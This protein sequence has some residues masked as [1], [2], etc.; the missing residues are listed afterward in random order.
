M[1]RG[2]AGALM[3]GSLLTWD[4]MFHVGFYRFI[5]TTHNSAAASGIID[6]P[7]VVQDISTLF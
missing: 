3:L 7:A 5:T 1:A 2:T 6:V 4:F